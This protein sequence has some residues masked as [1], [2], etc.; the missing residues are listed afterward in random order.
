MRVY[1]LS[2][3]TIF[4]QILIVYLYDICVYSLCVFVY[5]VRVL[6]ESW[7]AMCSVCLPPPPSLLCH[8]TTLP[9]RS[10]A[11][12]LFLFPTTAFFVTFIPSPFLLCTVFSTLD[13]CCHFLAVAFFRSLLCSHYHGAQLRY[14]NVLVS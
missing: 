10:H 7:L 5:G 3:S 9:H 6:L 1:M 12:F 13:P 11:C 8:R 2:T 4:A 14:R